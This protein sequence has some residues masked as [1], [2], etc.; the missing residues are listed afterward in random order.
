MF[1]NA[2]A[3]PGLLHIAHNLRATMHT[4]YPGEESCDMICFGTLGV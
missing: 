3:A 2:F 1:R 4:V